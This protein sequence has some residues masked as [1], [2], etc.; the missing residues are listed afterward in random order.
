M[1]EDYEQMIEDCIV[2]LEHMADHPF[3]EPEATAAWCAAMAHTLREALEILH[4]DT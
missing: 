1:V 4:Y 3:L 2:K